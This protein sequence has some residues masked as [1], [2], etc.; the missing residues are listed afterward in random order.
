MASGG[1]PK[2][3]KPNSTE[4]EAGNELYFNTYH[5]LLMNM[6]LDLD[7]TTQ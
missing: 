6:N 1:A 2:S 3:T 5:F 4:V 7:V